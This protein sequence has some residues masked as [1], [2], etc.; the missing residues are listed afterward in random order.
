MLPHFVGDLVRVDFADVDL[1]EQLAKLVAVIERV[2]RPLP[3]LG[4]STE[5]IGTPV[6]HVDDHLVRVVVLKLPLVFEDCRDVQ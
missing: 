1:F 3:V 5:A 2:F 6:V 4:Q